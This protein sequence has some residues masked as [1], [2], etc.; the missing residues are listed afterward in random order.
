METELSE[1]VIFSGSVAKDK[2]LCKL[3]YKPV[4]MP[5]MTKYHAGDNIINLSG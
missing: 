3:G 1:V 5:L 4:F 2:Y